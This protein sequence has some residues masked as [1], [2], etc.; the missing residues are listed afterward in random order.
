[1]IHVQSSH[2]EFRSGQVLWAL[3]ASVVTASCAAVGDSELALIDRTLRLEPGAQVADVGSGNGEVTVA[4]AARV[5]PEGKVLA[6]EIDAA[7]RR[8]TATRTAAMANVTVLAATSRD[9]G[10]PADSSDGI[11][12]RHVYHHLSEP[13]ATIEQLRDALRPGGRLLVI[14]FLPSRWLGLWTPPDLPAGRNGHG[15]DPETVIAE[16]VQTGMIHVKTI[17]PWPGHWMLRTFGLVF[18]RGGPTVD[19]DGSSR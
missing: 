13:L 5:G 19:V 18:E 17:D 11:V 2:S 6:S 9:S 14:D 8:A 3:V 12:L 16:V 7:K 1:M 15:I 4:L 10:I